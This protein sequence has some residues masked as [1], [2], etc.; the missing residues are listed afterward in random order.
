MYFF[1]LREKNKTRSNM[2]LKVF[3]DGN[4]FSTF[5]WHQS[6]HHF[7]TKAK[8]HGRSPANPSQVNSW[9][10]STPP[11]GVTFFGF[12]FAENVKSVQPGQR[13][14]VETTAPSFH[15]NTNTRQMEIS[16]SSL[17]SQDAVQLRS[18]SDAIN[19]AVIPVITL[20]LLDAPSAENNVFC[21]RTVNHFSPAN[22]RTVGTELRPAER[23]RLTVS[24]V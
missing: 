24:H 20:L 7:R 9:T 15:K 8:A 17:S 16:S 21:S 18:I 4:S 23:L 14:A 12:N 1:P 10:R 13:S 11:A 2:F 6:I 22:E 5:R 3:E 19:I